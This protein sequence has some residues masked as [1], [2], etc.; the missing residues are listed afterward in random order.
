MR[1]RVAWIVLI[2]HFKVTHL[3][4]VTDRSHGTVQLR[5][6][7]SGNEAGILTAFYLFF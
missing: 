5:L 6:T 7:A 2:Y 3:L 4:G 1:G